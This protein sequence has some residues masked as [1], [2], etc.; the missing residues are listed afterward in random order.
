MKRESNAVFSLILLP[1]VPSLNGSE[2]IEMSKL[3]EGVFQLAYKVTGSD[4]ERMVTVIVLKCCCALEDDNVDWIV[5]R[6]L[7]QISRGTRVDWLLEK[8]FNLRIYNAIYR[9]KCK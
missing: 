5:S 1:P 4:A 3:S 9:F 6:K 8:G 7:N 2:L